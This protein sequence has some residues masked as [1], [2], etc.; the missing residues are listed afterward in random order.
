[1]QGRSNKGLSGQGRMCHDLD[2]VNQG[3]LCKKPY[4][5]YQRITKALPSAHGLAL[6]RP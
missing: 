5:I 3:G 6:W 4:T 1:M 2:S